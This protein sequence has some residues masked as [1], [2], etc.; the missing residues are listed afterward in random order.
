MRRRRD[1]SCILLF[2]VLGIMMLA[3]CRRG[4]EPDIGRC[5]IYYVDTEETQL[6]EEYYNLKGS[7][8]E[9]KIQEVIELLNDI[10]DTIDCKSVFIS[11]VE[12]ERWEL[13][14]TKLNLYFNKRYSK[15]DKPSEILLRAAA[16]QSLVQISGVD[17]IC[18]YVGEKPLTDKDGREIGYMRAEDFV[19]NTGSS[20]HSFQTADLRLYYSNQ[21]GDKL[22]EEEV[23]V[24]YNSNM[25]IEKL[26]VEQLIKGPS[27]EDKKAVIPAGT[28]ILSVSVKDNICYVNFDE[29]F[30]KIAD[31]VNPKITIYALV[32]SIIDGGEA[33]QVQILVNGEANITY[34]ETI[35]LSKPLSRKADLIEEKE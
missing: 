5:R 27:S 13:Q 3:G 1:G 26:I 8:V 32:N 25:S 10:P 22:S 12:V 35:D 17:Y 19:Q 28:K 30:L 4:K 16:V 15:L 29:G 33:N 6:V 21:K 20:L 14:E 34:R 9:E 11:G 2:F 23:S 31:K 7:S 18:F 24:R